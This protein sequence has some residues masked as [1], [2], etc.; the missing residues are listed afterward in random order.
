MGTTPTQQIQAGV[1]GT[2]TLVDITAYVLP[3]SLSHT[4][5]RTNWQ[6]QVQPAGSISF[7][8]DNPDGRFTPGATTTYAVGLVRNMRI[9]W[10]CG[11]RVRIFY[12][13]TVSLEFPRGVSNRATVAVTG[14][15]LLGILSQRTMQAMVRE[16]TLAKKPVAYWPMDDTG[17]ADTLSFRDISG[18]AQSAL[19]VANKVAGQHF[20]FG[21]ATSNTQLVSPGAGRGPSTDG[22]AALILNNTGS[23]IDTFSATNYRAFARNIIASVDDAQPDTPTN[24]NRNLTIP[25]RTTPI[26]NGATYPAS[27]WNYNSGGSL[28]YAVSLW[29]SVQ[30]I[31]GATTGVGG[32][33]GPYVQLLTIDG[34]QITVTFRVANRQVGIHSPTDCAATASSWSVTP[35]AVHHLSIAVVDFDKQ[36]NSG[37]YA[38][39]DS[40]FYIYLD[41]NYMGMLNVKTPTLKVPTGVTVAAGPA[42]LFKTGATQTCYAFAGSISNV[43][44]HGP[45]GMAGYGSFD[46]SEIISTGTTG[47]VEGVANRIFRMMNWITPG[48]PTG[49][50][51]STYQNGTQ[52]SGSLGNV[53]PHDI[54]GK[55]ALTALCE[56]AALDDAA[57]TA[58]EISGYDCLNYWLDSTQRPLTPVLTV[59]AD[60]D[61][62]G[63]PTLGFDLTGVVQQATASTYGLATTFVGS[64][65]S[66]Q[67]AGSSDSVRCATQQGSAD[68]VKQLAAYRVVK[69]RAQKVSPTTVVVDATTSATNVTTTL[70][71]LYPGAT[72]AITGLPSDKLGYSSISCILI[73]VTEEYGLGRSA[74]TLRLIPRFPEMYFDP[75]LG[76]EGPWRFL[77]EPTWT[78][79][80]S[81]S[82][83]QAAGASGAFMGLYGTT[84]GGALNNSATTAYIISNRYTGP[85][86]TSNTFP[87]TFFT[88]DAADYP[89]TIKVDNEQM[90]ISSAA[91]TPTSTTI[92]GGTCWYQQVTVA[93]GA[94][95][96]AAVAHSAFTPTS[97]SGDQGFMVVQ[98]YENSPFLAF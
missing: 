66:S 50:I 1:N 51:A 6:S 71:G 23:P 46:A 27:G 61:L 52:N 74:F 33:D 47:P 87:T 10:T 48:L 83:L 85:T 63:T 98:P 55:D 69:G 15:D 38:A 29:F 82:N 92:N 73:G 57:F 68:L 64:G 37:F 40:Q 56:V 4:Y 96:T 65:A 8:L 5:G 58:Q 59:D 84:T 20:T 25:D 45:S 34:P 54:T 49:Q 14:T 88:Q 19:Y 94:N 35:N 67:F 80:P 41:G 95:G 3:G 60:A 62:S 16:A 77:D 90:T 28:Q 36:W 32:T 81:T 17:N 30:D 91:G 13:S 78:L 86:A 72:V 79:N 89:L 7:T 11:S 22:A 26:S 31:Y 21:G 75:N 93:R 42:N 18:N 24:N 97:L 39:S 53:G 76:T 44:I 9:R 70:L 12:L 43:S 2:G